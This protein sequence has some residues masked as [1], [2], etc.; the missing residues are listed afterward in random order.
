MTN[1]YKLVDAEGYTDNII[2]IDNIKNYQ[3]P[4]GLTLELDNGIY[5][6]KNS[7]EVQKRNIITQIALLEN[8]QTSRLIREAAL[9]NN[10]A[11]NKLTELDNQIKELRKQL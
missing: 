9:D 10:F 4:E 6:Y 3:V 1:R 5:N 7:N 2:L 8:Q 11:K